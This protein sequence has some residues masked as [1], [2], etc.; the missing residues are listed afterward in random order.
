MLWIPKDD[1][2]MRNIYQEITSYLHNPLFAIYA[3][4]PPSAV[5]HTVTFIAIS[6]SLQI[7]IIIYPNIFSIY[8]YK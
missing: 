8:V 2:K 5:L 4:Y 6:N 7:L 1:N 3:T